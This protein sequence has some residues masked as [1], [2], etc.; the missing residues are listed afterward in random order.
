MTNDWPEWRVRAWEAPL[1]S[2]SRFI[3]VSVSRFIM[4]TPLWAVLLSF[5]IV[6]MQ[7]FLL[8]Y[9][10]DM[11]MHVLYHMSY[12]VLYIM[13]YTSTRDS[14]SSLLST[15]G[16]FHQERSVCDLCVTPGGDSWHLSYSSHHLKWVEHHSY[17]VSGPPT[18]TVTLDSTSY[19]HHDSS[20]K[21][22]TMFPPEVLM[23]MCKAILNKEEEEHQ[24]ETVAKG[25]L[26]EIFKGN[27]TKAKH[28]IYEFATYFMA[29]DEEP[30]LASPVAQVALT[31]SWIKGEEV[32]P[33]VDQQLQWLEMQDCQDPK[34]GEAFV[35]KFFKQFVPKGRWQTIARIEMKWPYLD[36]YILD[37]EKTHVHGTRLLKGVEW[38]QRFIKGLAGSVKRAMTNWFQTYEKAKEEACCIVG[39]QKILHQV[40]KRRNNTWTNAQGQ[41]QKTLQPMTPGKVTSPV[42]FREEQKRLKKIWQAHRRMAEAPLF[43]RHPSTFP[44]SSPQQVTMQEIQMGNI[45][46]S[47]TIPTIDDLCTQLEGL[48]INEQKEVIQCLHIAQGE[49]YSQLV[50]SAWR[51]RSD[52]EGIY[53]SIWKS[54]QLHVFIHLTHKWDKATALLDSGA[55]ENFIQEAYAWQLKLPIKCLPYTQPVYNID[56]TLNKNGHI[57]SYTNPEM[58]T[59]QQRTKL[60]FFLTD[61]G[62]QKLILGYPWFTATQPNIDWA[63]GWIEAKQLLLI[64]CAPEKKKDCISKC[65]TTPTGRCTVWRPYAPANGSLYIARIQIS[66]QELKAMR[67]QTMAS[68]LAEQAGSQKGSGEIPA[69]YQWHS[70][71]FSE[72]AAQHFPESRIWDHAIELK[73]NAPSM[74]PGKVYQL[75]QEE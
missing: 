20:R 73:P 41:T 18:L 17:R 23:Y 16:L 45:N 70:H 39:V 7:F 50:Q 59:G 3:I 68:K 11:L 5:R 52:V 8:Y 33:W 64:I 65:N 1:V 29:H 75:M 24:K 48:T 67:K 74:I 26:P 62:D 31:L 53:L 13:Q 19:T 63:R 15:G 9:Y 12:H 46:P 66:G 30:V 34:V 61:I 69:K 40:Y 10:K 21:D 47:A 35:E 57:H 42:H 43:T 32:D 2:F 51:W 72:E 44:T 27:P 49:S 22:D 58:Q 28:F 56:G 36:E 38:V 55:T 37:F 60:H 14:K 25:K 4:V 6:L 71:V 54:M